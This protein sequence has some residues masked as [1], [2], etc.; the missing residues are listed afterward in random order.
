M[1]LDSGKEARESGNENDVKLANLESSLKEVSGE[2]T[3]T[4]KKVEVFLHA[5]RQVI[6]KLE[7]YPQME[8]KLWIEQWEEVITKIKVERRRKWWKEW[9]ERFLRWGL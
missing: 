4:W 1:N 5:D 8:V 3:W 9:F 6:L 7:G 2:G